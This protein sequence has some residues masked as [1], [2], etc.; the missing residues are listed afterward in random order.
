[1]RGPKASPRR[2]LTDWTTPA[3]VAGDGLAALVAAADSVADAI[4]LATLGYEVFVLDPVT[5]DAAAPPPVHVVDLAAGD[6]PDAWHGRFALV[7]AD[8]ATSAQVVPCVAEA[9]LLVVVDDAPVPPDLA[10]GLVE[11]VVEVGPDPDAPS[12]ERFRAVHARL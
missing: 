12:V 5:P 1:M 2:L 11:V 9:G 3:G 8:A 10:P 6:L 4:H 7:V